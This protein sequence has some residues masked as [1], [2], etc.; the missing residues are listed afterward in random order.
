[1]IRTGMGRAGV[2]RHLVVKAR[3]LLNTRART[4]PATEVPAPGD[5]GIDAKEPWLTPRS[6]E[7]PRGV[8]SGRPGAQSLSL[9]WAP[10]P[11][12]PWEA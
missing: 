10:R 1:M 9:A 12:L 11:L 4:V 6:G 7:R 5:S 3:G 8:G 2:Y